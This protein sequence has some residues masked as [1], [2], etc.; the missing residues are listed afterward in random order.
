MHNVIDYK[1]IFDS[2]P[3]YM[4]T[5]HIQGIDYLKYDNCNNNNIDVKQR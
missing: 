2:K 3:D 5:Y 4:Y 1:I